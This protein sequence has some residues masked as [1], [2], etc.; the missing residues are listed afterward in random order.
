MV[1]LLHSPI[2]SKENNPPLRNSE[3]FRD[4]TL[5]FFNLLENRI[6]SKVSRLFP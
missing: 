3:I 1:R 6:M 4:M 2:P 5:R